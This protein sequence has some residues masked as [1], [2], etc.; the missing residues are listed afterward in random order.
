MFVHKFSSIPTCECVSFCCKTLF[1]MFS[2]PLGKLVKRFVSGSTSCE[3]LLMLVLKRGV[4]YLGWC[5][6][7]TFLAPLK[8]ILRTDNTSVSSATSSQSSIAAN[9]HLFP[10]G[11]ST[12]SAA[13]QCVSQEPA[14]PP[15]AAPPSTQP[16][17]PTSHQVLA[18]NQLF[19]APPSGRGRGPPD[20]PSRFSS[21]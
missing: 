19:A 5:I 15:P 20:N 11:P 18:R 8:Y 12:N 21:Q 6:P 16:A 17:C 9:S 10:A 1:A 2:F 14:R 4:G 3:I 7:W 13:S